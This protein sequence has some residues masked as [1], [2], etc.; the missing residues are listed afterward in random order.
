MEESA[1]I[2]ARLGFGMLFIMQNEWSKC[3]EDILKFHA[4]SEAAGFAPKPPIILTNI[5]VRRANTKFDD[6]NAQI[7]KEASR[8]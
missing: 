8:K 1:E 3:R 5:Y 2:I 7:I 6:M 4:M